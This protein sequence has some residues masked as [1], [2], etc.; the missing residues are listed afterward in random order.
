MARPK[1]APDIYLH[2]ARGMGTAPA[3]CL[4][5]EDSPTGVRAAAAAGMA[6]LGFVGAGHVRDAEALGAALMAE[7]A[8]ALL[9]E[10]AELHLG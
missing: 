2:A 7:G 1:P 4:V 9:S 10:L 6:V 3:A 5:I 8:V